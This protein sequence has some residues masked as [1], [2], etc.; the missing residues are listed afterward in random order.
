[1]LNDVSAMNPKGN[2]KL[3]L[4]NEEGIFFTKEKKN[5]VVTSANEIVANMM[6][7]PAKTSRVLETEKGET[8]SISNEEGYFV[9]NMK[10]Q[11][12]SIKSASQDILSTNTEKTFNI[13][14]MKDVT[15]LLSVQVGDNSLVINEDV[16]IKDAEVGV[17]EFRE[18]PKAALTVKYQGLQG[19][20]SKLIEG[21][22]SVSINGEKWTRANV[23]NDTNKQYAINYSTGEISFQTS[24]SN[25]EVSYSYLK[26]YGLGF[27]GLGGKPESHPEHQPVSFSQMDKALIRMDNEFENARMPVLYPSVIEEG[28]PE[29]EVLPTI[30]MAT[31]NITANFVSGDKDGDTNIDVVYP[32]DVNGKKLLEIIS[33]KKLA[34]EGEEVDQDLVVGDDIAIK[35]ANAATVE[36][37][38]IPMDGNEYQVEVKVQ[39][40]NLHLNYQLSTAP[41]VE[42]VR[43]VHEDANTNEVV[44]YN[45]QDRGMRIGSG[46]VWMMNANAG[47]M[48][49]SSNPSNGVPVHTPGQLTI[50]YKVNSGTVVKFIADFPKG[51]P[52]AVRTEKTETFTSSGESTFILSN[53]ISKTKEGSFEV[54]SV[55]RNGNAEIFNVQADGKRVDVDSV[56]SGDNVVITYFFNKEAHEIY[57]VAMFDEKEAST[58]KMFNI[59]G[60]GPVTKDAN[61]GM[62]ITWSVTF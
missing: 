8:N 2:V 9:Y 11:P 50:E 7:N 48:Q 22:E 36:F 14:D 42:L 15:E 55:T 10:I 23:P 58:S 13:T 18:A 57:Q 30:P 20:Q 60:I 51:V 56:V 28:K 31:K 17:I 59:S 24:K 25:V 1:M 54:S 6:S 3:E 62:R 39:D 41:I 16:F 61:T 34:G 53:A 35:D 4:Y 33:A 19:K 5:L 49:F 46:D 38:E 37:T 44:S 43:V 26:Q 32:L 21:T 47:I 27:M 40:N 52:G 45:I 29:L 12:E